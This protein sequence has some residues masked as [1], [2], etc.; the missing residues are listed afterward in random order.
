MKLPTLALLAL[1]CMLPTRFADAQATSRASVS[2]AGTEGNGHS[3][4]V[5]VSSS[6]RYVLFH[7][8][9]SNLVAN[10]VNGAEDAFVHDRLTGTTTL[11]SVATGGAQGN[12]NSRGPVMSADERVVAF[13]SLSDNL[14]PN[15]TNAADDVFVHEL[16]TGVTT[17]VSVSSTGEGSAL[18]A[19]GPSISGDGRFVGFTSLSANLV[20]GDL[21]SVD[22]VFVHD[23]ATATTVRASEALGGGAGDRDSYFA[24]LSGDG[25]YLAFASVA[26]DL[27]PGDTNVQQD[28]FVRDLVAGTTERVS[29]ATGGGEGHGFSF[30][31]AISAD[32]GHVAFHS[33]AAD[34]VASDANAAGDVFVRDRIAATTVIASLA[35]DGAQGNGTAFACA[36]SAHGRH[37]AFD[38]V[39]TNL[40]A[41]D[42]NGVD[43]LFVRDLLSGRT[44]RVAV[45]SDGTQGDLDSRIPALS[46]NGRIVAFGSGA[47]TLVAGDAN[48]LLDVFVRDRG[49]LQ[50]TA[51]CFGD[52]TAACPCANAG[53]PGRGCENSAGTGGALLTTTGD[54]APDTLVLTVWGELPGALSVFLQGD[55][56]HAPAAFGDGLLCAGGTLLRLYVR[57]AQAGSASAPGPGDP[58]ITARS[59]A[60]GDPIAPGSTRWYQVHYRDPDPGFCP[61]PQ[62]ATWNASHALGMLW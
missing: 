38:S 3:F 56:V 52:A 31:P 36:I 11:V 12:A 20:P 34:L 50:A 49:E 15:D 5:T 27:V 44:E 33:L 48:G 40:V 9:A 62:G 54:H 32:G 37:V 60:L 41:G 7:S 22:D 47:T 8:A 1:A 42:T 25:R 46:A 4:R 26:T 24:S 6:G 55:L 16:A 53:A 13:H 2:S 45:A 57:N 29:V 14:S 59:A 18:L 10:D 23:S 21:N 58:S 19:R 35:D 43:D 30:Y 51:T 17:R 61:A 28:I 39:A